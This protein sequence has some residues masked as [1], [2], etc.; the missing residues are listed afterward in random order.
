MHHKVGIIG[1]AVTAS[2]IV[3]YSLANAYPPAVG[4]L[5]KADNC[6]PCHLNN[7]KWTEGANL[8]IDIV[9][10]EN[11]KS[12]RQSDGTFLITAKRGQPVTVL[13]II[14]YKTSETDLV[15]YRNAWLYIDPERIKSSSLSKFAPGW[16]VNLPMACRLVGDKSEF[17]QNANVTVLP[18]TVRP[19]DSAKDAVVALQVMLTKGES[20]KGDA[21]K[22]MVG[23]YFE[24]TVYLS[25]VE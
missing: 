7:G 12:L 15:P 18:M 5:G 19:A 23:S 22:G 21:K 14:G 11:G 6:L 1:M 20:V 4:I 13:T 16:E 10:K 17:Y 24:R 2:L 9:D 3:V 25:V 8:I